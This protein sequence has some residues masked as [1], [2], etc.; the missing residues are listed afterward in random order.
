MLAVLKKLVHLE[1]KIAPRWGAGAETSG[2]TNIAPRWG[3][4]TQTSGS[5]NMRTPLGWERLKGA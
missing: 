5:T 1:C 3:A 2:S 4:G